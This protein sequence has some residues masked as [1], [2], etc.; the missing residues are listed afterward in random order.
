MKMTVAHLIKN[1]SSFILFVYLMQV[2]PHSSVAEIKSL[3]HKSCKLDSTVNVL[4]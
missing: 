1:R 2:E 3:F 4:L